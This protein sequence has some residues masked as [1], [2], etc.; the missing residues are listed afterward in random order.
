VALQ[1]VGDQPVTDR[2]NVRGVGQSQTVRGSVDGVDTALPTGSVTFLFTD[3]EGSTVLWEEHGEQMAV[4]LAAHDRC[5]RKA[6]ADHNGYIFTTA[7]DSFCMAFHRPEAALAAAVEAQLALRE[8]MASLRIKVRMGIHAG[9][10]IVR[11]GDYFGPVLNRTARLMAVGHGGQILIS[12][13][14]AAIVGDQLEE[15]LGLTDLGEHQLKDLSRPEHVYQLHHL[16]LEERFPPLRSI[17]TSS[18]NLPVQLTSFVG[19]AAELEDAAALLRE[20]RLL[21]VTGTGGAGKTRLAMQLGADLLDEFPAGVRLVELAPLPD[22]DLVIDEVANVLGVRIEP[23]QAVID[24]IVA[25]VGDRK[26]LL[27]LDNCEHLIDVVAELAENLLLA[28]PG[29]KILATSIELLRVPGEVTYRLPPLSLPREE[30]E[31]EDV[32]QHDAVRLFTERA[33]QAQPDFA[34]TR[35]N[36][37]S[38]VAIT[39]RLDGMPLGLELAAARLRSLSVDQIADRLDERFRLLSGGRRTKVARHQ[40]LQAAIDWSHDLLTA[41]EQVLFRRLSVFA[42]NFTLPAAEGVACAPPL[43]PLDAYDL[44]AE[45]VDKSML[46]SEDGPNGERRFRLLESLRRYGALK[47]RDAGED[48]EAQAR[49]LEYFTVLADELDQAAVSGASGGVMASLGADEDN[50]RAALT[51]A[52]DT[53]RLERAAWIITRLWFLWYHAGR[54]RQVL[55]WSTELFARDPDL[56]DELLAW[57]LHA[58]GTMLGVWDEPEAGI[59]VLEREVALRRGMDDARALSSALNNLGNLLHSAGRTDEAVAAFGSAIAAKRSAGLPVAAELNSLGLVHLDG[60]EYEA[61]EALFTESLANAT[62][63]RDAYGIAQATF[64]LGQTAARRGRP[65]VARPLLD[66]ARGSFVDQGVMPGVAEVDFFLALVDRSEGKRGDA[67]H[68][69][70]ASLDVSDSHWSPSLTFWILQVAATVI[71]DRLVAAE[72]LGA[73]VEHAPSTKEAQ[74]PY[75]VR[76]LAAAQDDL[77]RHIGDDVFA[78]RFA[79]G[80]HMAM[81]D[82]VAS[83]RHALREGM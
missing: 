83:A 2:G 17:R 43:D 5:L 80:G 4:A 59:P 14:L 55:D 49:H 16:D 75:F 77:R 44:I 68:R 36:L 38:V 7:G 34:V 60:E 54:S 52:L 8:P 31:L 70:L 57:A 65:D 82:A 39:Q 45:L 42:G 11:D 32:R 12:G 18:T 22:P 71:R 15:P 56:D 47:L 78:A 27:V 13:A 67:I 74:P 23:D 37:K 33:V 69:L 30:E 53:E 28:C 10:A 25:K 21:T 73:V 40:T 20:S 29:L 81:P 62:E 61:A 9:D 41:N 26:L 66:E 76:D 35:H 51:F 48:E 46:A 6:A 1:H 64:Y 58:H 72:L 19:R 79:A 24:T 3:V 63:E 50:F